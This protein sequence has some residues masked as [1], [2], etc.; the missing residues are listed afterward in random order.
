MVAIA[1][2]TTHRSY[3][4]RS[5]LVSGELGYSPT[6]HSRVLSW[7]FGGGDAELDDLVD[8]FLAAERDAAG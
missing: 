2:T 7:G 8:E 3:N 1:T 4:R 5:D 6:R